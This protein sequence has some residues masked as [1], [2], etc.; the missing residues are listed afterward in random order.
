MGFAIKHGQHASTSK[1]PY[2]SKIPKNMNQ[3]M[4]RAMSNEG[5]IIIEMPQFVG[6]YSMMKWNLILNHMMMMKKTQKTM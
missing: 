6:F 2:G 4:Q 3:D 1:Q 5:G